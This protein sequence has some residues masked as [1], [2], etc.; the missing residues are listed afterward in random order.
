M[1][2][3]AERGHARRHRAADA[4][5]APNDLRVTPLPL[6]AAPGFPPLPPQPRVRAICDGRVG[7]RR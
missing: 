4:A 7:A 2:G 5:D 1:V 6:T 3:E